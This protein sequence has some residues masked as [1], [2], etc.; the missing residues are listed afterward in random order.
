LLD[1]ISVSPS[2]LAVGYEVLYLSR[3]Y[4]LGVP[5]IAFVG[6]DLRE[7]A[8]YLDILSPFILPT[9][10]VRGIAIDFGGVGDL[11]AFE[12][13]RAAYGQAL[14][15]RGDLRAFEVKRAIVTVTVKFREI[16][17]LGDEL[18]DAVFCH[19]ELF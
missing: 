18:F 10:W 16:S 8:I 6:Y 14:G 19:S 9:H 11:R 5:Y 12:V 3:A 17:I 4:L 15:E 13:K 1:V 7:D 2:A